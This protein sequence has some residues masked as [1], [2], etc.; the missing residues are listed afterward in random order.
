MLL[1]FPVAISASGTKRTWPVYRMMSVPA[2]KADIL[3]LAATWLMDDGETTGGVP[4]LPQGGKGSGAA[5]MKGQPISASKAKKA[6][7]D[8]KKAVG[9]ADGMAELSIFYCEEA[10]GFLESCSI[11]DEL[12]FALLL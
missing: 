11:E 10:F 3:Q 5:L 8:Y 7:A 1:I 12:Y 4:E 2:A 6:I 9:R